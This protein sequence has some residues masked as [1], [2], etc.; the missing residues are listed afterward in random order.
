MQDLFKFWNACSKPDFLI[1]DNFFPIRLYLLP[2]KIIMVI[3]AH[4]VLLDFILITRRRVGSS[5]QTFGR[6]KSVIRS[7]NSSNNRKWRCFPVYANTNPGW[8]FDYWGECVLLYFLVCND[9]KI[10]LEKHRAKSSLIFFF[11]E[12]CTKILNVFFFV[13]EIVVQVHFWKKSAKITIKREFFGFI[14]KILS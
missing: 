12:G 13:I 7:T 1:E 8:K 2:Q 10:S 6:K 5:R 3:Y 11:D 4:F 9:K 14:L